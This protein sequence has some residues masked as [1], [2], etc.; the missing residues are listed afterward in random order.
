MSFP[1]EENSKKSQV[2][3]FCS[4]ACSMHRVGPTQNF[5]DRKPD[6]TAFSHVCGFFHVAI[7]GL[8]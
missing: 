8:K 5:P 6:Q 3:L 2:S 7:G 1:L 4:L